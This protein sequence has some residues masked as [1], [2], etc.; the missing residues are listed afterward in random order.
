MDG[1]EIW[2]AVLS[3]WQGEQPV[4]SRNGGGRIKNGG[5]VEDWWP[6]IDGRAER[7]AANSSGD[8]R[9]RG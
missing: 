3:W 4:S 9:M 6:V 5:A 2:P 8:E 7:Y 1:G